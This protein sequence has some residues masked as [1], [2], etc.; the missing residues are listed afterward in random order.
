MLYF[1]LLKLNLGGWISKKNKRKIV[2]LLISFIVCMLGNIVMDK[3][4]INGIHYYI[5]MGLLFS[6]LISIIPFISPKV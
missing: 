2:A 5:V 4:R 3:L 1:I 6:L